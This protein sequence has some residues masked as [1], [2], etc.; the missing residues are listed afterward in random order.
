MILQFLFLSFSVKFL[1]TF[2]ITYDLKD[3]D[4][5]F[6]I[7]FQRDQEHASTTLKLYNQANTCQKI[8]KEMKNYTM[9]P[10]ISL[11]N[12]LQNFPIFRQYTAEGWS[13]PAMKLE[14]IISAKVDQNFRFQILWLQFFKNLENIDEN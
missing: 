8:R 2:S 10:K 3:E 9:V 7:G 12:F 13:Q 5:P 11:P 6:S 1:S 4:I 14:F